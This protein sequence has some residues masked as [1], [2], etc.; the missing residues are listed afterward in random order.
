MICEILQPIF[1]ALDGEFRFHGLECTL[2]CRS[3]RRAKWQIGNAQKLRR[4]KQRKGIS[5]AS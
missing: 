2:N 4:I 3:V 5:L 1:D